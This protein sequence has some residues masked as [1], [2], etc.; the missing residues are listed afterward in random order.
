MMIGLALCLVVAA[1]PCAQ[2]APLEAQ[3]R[4]LNT[5]MAEVNTW[6]LVNE[7]DLSPAQ[8][9][10]LLPA[11]R[12]L[13]SEGEAIEAEQTRSV[14]EFDRAIRVLRQEL[15]AN[16]GV[17]DQAKAGV[18]R[19]E[20][21]WRELE[22]KSEERAPQRCRIVQQTLT[23]EQL[24]VVATYRP[25]AAL[26]AAKLAR[27]GAP[28]A[29]ARAEEV[30]TRAR[31]ATPEQLE[32][33]PQR[34]RQ[35]LPPGRPGIPP[36]RLREVAGQIRGIVM[37]ARAMSDSDFAGRKAELAQRLV[38][39]LPQTGAPGARPGRHAKG[40]DLERKIGDMLLTPALATVLE[41][42]LG[43]AQP[44]P[45]KAP[46]YYPEDVADA[47]NDVRLLN[48]VNSLYLSP[49]QMKALSAIISRAEAAREAARPQTEVVL[50][51]LIA[52][53][54]HARDELAAGGLSAQTL[55]RARAE[56]A[57]GMEEKRAHETRMAQYVAEVKGVLNENQ[58]CLVSEFIPC[59]IPIKNLTNPERIGQA[60]N[61]QGAE[62]MLA[63]ARAASEEQIAAMMPRAQ[64][65]LEALL[66]HKHLPAAEI[67]AKVAELPRVLAEARAMSDTEFELKKTELVKRVA[68]PEPTAVEGP[69]LDQRIA[70]YL[71]AANLLPI[72]EQ[73]IA[74]P[75]TA[76]R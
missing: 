41:A 32:Q 51:D 11:A 52:L 72:F 34:L 39:L 13:R 45:F 70:Q 36:A 20:G 8:M 16:N 75:G 57:R 53:A 58:I 28:G 40:A 30:L 73:R 46:A 33:A 44:G 48:L 22:N 69:A 27:R 23:P 35:M 26:G 15:L 50:G 42:K 56:A 68:P 43:I 17:S 71:L 63:Q 38:D 55:E 74:A 2:A 19:A 59:L 21:G 4:T 24:E 12:E 76:S 18:A 47:V 5:L 7:L 65:R 61:T 25:G 1:A 49:D 6:N 31:Q 10:A 3:M 64:E 66:R 29:L 62:R 60:Q 67:E 9:Q 54:T 37:E 14:A